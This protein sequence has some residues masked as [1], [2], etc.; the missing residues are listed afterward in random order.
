MP[1]GVFIRTKPGPN[2]GKI[3]KDST[4]YK[5]GEKDYR[6][7]EWTNKILS[8]GDNFCYFCTEM[9][10]TNE[11]MVAHHLYD[12]KKYPDLKYDPINGVKAHNRCHSSYHMKGVKKSKE[13]NEK[14]SKTQKAFHQT[15]EGKESLRKLSDAI[16]E[17]WTPERLEEFSKQRTEFYNSPEGK[18]LLKKGW[19][20]RRRNQLLKENTI[21]L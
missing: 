12:K 3:G 9:I 16:K 4:N 7:K 2:K 15:P 5:N 18:E 13:A 19:E 8:I 11:R 17:A 20:T 14:S 6:I 21:C 10:L 1:K